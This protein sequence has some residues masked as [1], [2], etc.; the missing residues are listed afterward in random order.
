MSGGESN[1]HLCKSNQ[2]FRDYYASTKQQILAN[3]LEQFPLITGSGISYHKISV[4]HLSQ[5]SFSAGDQLF[6]LWKLQR[7]EGNAQSS[8]SDA[9]KS[10][11]H[12]PTAIYVLLQTLLYGQPATYASVYHH[13]LRRSCNFPQRESI[14]LNGD[15]RAGLTSVIAMGVRALSELPAVLRASQLT[16]Q[17]QIVSASRAFSEGLLAR[18]QVS[19]K[20]L[21]AFARDT[22]ALIE[23]N[24]EDA[25][26]ASLDAYG[27]LPLVVSSFLTC[28]WL[29]AYTLRSCDG[30]RSTSSI[31]PMLV[32]STRPAT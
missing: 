13:S 18:G 20:E 2:L 14:P 23:A 7:I 3:F 10:V 28:C 31:G 32:L 15:V 17:L 21:E 12:L 9:L 24:V 26:A 30:K 29:I 5:L 22:V 25:A 4:V 8:L 19:A 11:S 16:R 27:S 1:P 6:L